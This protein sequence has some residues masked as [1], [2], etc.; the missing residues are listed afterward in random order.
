[1]KQKKISKVSQNEQGSKNQSNR[2]QSKEKSKD[3]VAKS[4]CSQPLSGVSKSKTYEK[5]K[6][7]L[8]WETVLTKDQ[9]KK[10]FKKIYK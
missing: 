1:M 5:Q 8:D 10:P 7:E 4:K 9:Q 3:R 2:C 6:F